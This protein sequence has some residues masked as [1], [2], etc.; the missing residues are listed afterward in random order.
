[1]AGATGETAAGT[2]QA[3]AGVTTAVAESTPR[4]NANAGAPTVPGTA[5]IEDTTPT[6][7]VVEGTA[8]ADANVSISTTTAVIGAATVPGTDVVVGGDGHAYGPLDPHGA[9]PA[10]GG[11]EPSSGGGASTGRSA[12]LRPTRAAIATGHR[13]DVAPA[14]Q[15][16]LVRPVLSDDRG[17]S[18]GV[19]ALE[20]AGPAGRTSAVVRYAGHVTR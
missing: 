12:T 2:A 9:S 8:Q 5:T 17:G 20:G 11:P 6:S 7:P 4:A 16:A 18:A 14:Q 19:R 15:L 13:L 3:D 10:G 1:M